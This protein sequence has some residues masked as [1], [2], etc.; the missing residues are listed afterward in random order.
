MHLVE[1]LIFWQSQLAFSVNWGGE[2]LVAWHLAIACPNVVHENLVWSLCSLYSMVH[3]V[4]LVED[5]N[6]SVITALHLLLALGAYTPNTFGESSANNVLHQV[7]F[8]G[9]GGKRHK[10][11]RSSC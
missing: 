7:L 1:I 4:G 10:L 9:L 6:A 11:S 8:C 2:D 5:S 3:A